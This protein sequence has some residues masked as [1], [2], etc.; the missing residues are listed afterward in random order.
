VAHRI[1]R[2]I[3]LASILVAFAQPELGRLVDQSIFQAIPGLRSQSLELTFYKS[4]SFG[5]KSC[6]QVTVP[7]KWRNLYLQILSGNKMQISRKLRKLDK[8]LQMFPQDMQVYVIFHQPTRATL[9]KL[10]FSDPANMGEHLLPSSEYG[11]S[12]RRNA[13]GYDIVRRDL[14]KET[15]SR[16]ISWR[17]KEHHG[18]D[19][20]EREGIVDKSFQCYPRQHVEAYSQELRIRINPEGFPSIASGPFD[21][22]LDDS[23][24][25]L[26][27]TIRVY[28]EIFGSC[29]IVTN[30]DNSTYQLKRRQ[31]NWIILPAGRR[32][33]DESDSA[34]AKAIQKISISSQIVVKNRLNTILTYEPDFSAYGQHGFNRYVIYGWDKEKL[35]LLESTE[36]DNATYVLNKEWEI[37]SRLSKAE[38]LAADEHQVRLIHHK[39][40]AGELN[41]LMAAYGIYAGK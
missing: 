39:G 11:A 3:Q 2:Q 22:H 29:E 19:I 16:Q 9:N 32:P 41:R 38:V 27:N 7:R 20:V 13:N 12:C 15:R 30:P 36:V 31:L 35:Y 4:A 40:W 34:I 24:S 14:P 8:V 10:G 25:S 33:W 28:V 23:K 37:L 26:L 18:K 6:G 17:W 1:F 5:T 21:L